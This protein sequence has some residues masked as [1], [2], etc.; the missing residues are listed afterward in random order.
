MLLHGTPVTGVELW[1]TFTDTLYDADLWHT[2]TLEKYYKTI[3]PGCRYFRICMDN[4][5]W[6]THA[7]GYTSND[8]SG[9]SGGAWF[10]FS[11][12]SATRL[13]GFEFKGT[14]GLDDILVAESWSGQGSSGDED[15]DGM[16]DFWE[17]QYFG[18]TNQ[19]SGD[20]TADWD[21]DGF[22]NLSE[23]L[24][25]TS[26][27]DTNSV[28]AIRNIAFEPGGI[29]LSWQGGRASTQYLEQR[30]NLTVGSWQTIFTNL[31]P[32][33]IFNELIDVDAAAP[34]R[35]YRIR[36]VRE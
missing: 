12:L 13:S 2:V 18:G 23:W 17:Y 7:D 26:P 22:D 20:A 11:D 30:D 31:P 1:S 32:T 35:F 6:L 9:S 19:T 16:W 14:L 10:A 15:N 5:P 29:S 28:L 36:A 25:D 33:D 4:G 21:N 27:D 3:G 8:G 24:A 34:H